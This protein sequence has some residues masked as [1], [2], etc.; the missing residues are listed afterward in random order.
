MGVERI[1]EQTERLAPLLGREHERA[2]ICHLLRAPSVRLL[3]LTGPGGVGKTRVGLQTAMDLAGEF[4]DGA[5]FVP[6]GAVTD[7]AFVAN[8]IAEQLNLRE[9]G[10]QPLRE[11]L[12]AF[13]WSRR[14]L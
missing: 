3:T 7:P 8:A 6:L 12:E 5:C 11:Q 14:L 1:I 9:R 10:D 4:G 13:L 2:E